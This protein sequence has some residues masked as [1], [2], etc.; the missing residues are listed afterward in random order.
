MKFFHRRNTMVEGKLAGL[1]FQASRFPRLPMTSRYF[2]LPYF[3]K[4][5]QITTY[6]YYEFFEQHP[7]PLIENRR[8]RLIKEVQVEIEDDEELFIES[9]WWRDD[10]AK[11]VRENEWNP[12]P[13]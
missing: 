7:E 1:T 11:K 9:S 4:I 12:C 5:T 13:F 8:Y 3:C 2:V 10:E 6:C